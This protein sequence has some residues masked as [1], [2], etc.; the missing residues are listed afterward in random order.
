MKLIPLTQGKFAMVDDSD[1][2]Y[3]IQWKWGFNGRKDGSGYAIRSVNYHRPDGKRRVK[4][5]Y[6]HRIIN[7]TP[8]GMLTDHRDGDGLNNQRY[9]LR[10]ATNGQNTQN[11][12]F[13]K[14]EFKGVSFCNVHK[15]WIA[16]ICTNGKRKYLG[17]FKDKYDAAL[18]YNFHAEKMHGEF[19]VFNGVK[20]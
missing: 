19:A 17:V 6:M 1:Y 14:M 20:K 13:K 3:L 10:D 4:R 12:K 18:A 11:S 2:D 9:N 16:R 7:S 15:G 8:I 5:I